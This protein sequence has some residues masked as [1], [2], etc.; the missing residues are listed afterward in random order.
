MDNV[1]EVSTRNPGRPRRASLAAGAFALA[2]FSLL[3]VTPANAQVW[4]EVGDAGN[5]PGAAQTTF[6]AGPLFTI[7][8][9]LP[10]DADVDM[11]C[12]HIADRASFTASLNCLIQLEED[13]YLFDSTG[14]GVALAQNCSAGQKRINNT[15]VTSSGTYY[16]AVA[17]HGALAEA[18]GSDIWLAGLT[19][20]RAPDGPGAAGV[21][22]GW[23]GSP[24]AQQGF[25]NYSITLTGVG[26][27]QPLVTPAGRHSWGHLKS[28]YR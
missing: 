13:L 17:W 15:F 23:A 9:S 19:S 26:Y 2:A 5:L 21:L 20:E 6:G 14:K 11:Y 3:A 16:L 4:N 24:V 18:G 25:A 22:T 8:G 1:I 28:I 27:C 7:T 12:I 10:T